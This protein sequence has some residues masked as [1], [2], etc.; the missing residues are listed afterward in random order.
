MAEASYRAAVQAA[1]TSQGTLTDGWQVLGLDRSTAQRIFDEEAKEGFVS[2]RQVMYGGQT[3]K[4]DKKGR[5]LDADGKPKDHPNETKDLDSDYPS[6]AVDSD[7]TNV[8]EC[9]N[10]GFTIFI[11][12]GRESKF[13]GQG[14]KCPECGATRD[15]FKER[16]D[17]EDTE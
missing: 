4:Y 1:G 14:F 3:R 17:V 10:C 16:A 6:E 11:A 5:V 2:A 13:Y 12:P 9:G 15:K 8:Y 7:V